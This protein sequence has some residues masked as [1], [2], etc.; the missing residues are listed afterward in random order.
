[1]T[2]A[3]ISLYKQSTFWTNSGFPFCF[4]T[5]P[6][7]RL[8]APYWLDY[9][10]APDDQ[11]TLRIK[12]N[13]VSRD[14]D[15][16]YTEMESLADCY[17]QEQSFFWDQGAQV[18]T[19]H[20]EHE[21]RPTTATM[22]FGAVFGVTDTTVKY[23]DDIEY[24]PLIAKAPVYTK[25][26]DF[27]NYDKLTFA[28]G[29]LELGGDGYL[30]D[31]LLQYPLKGNQVNL[32]YGDEDDD[33]DDLIEMDIFYV[34][35]FSSTLSKLTLELQDLRKS[36]EMEIPISV[37]SPDDYPDLEEDYYNKPVP[38]IYG[39]NEDVPCTPVNGLE[40]VGSTRTYRPGFL[41]TENPTNVMVKIDNAWVVRTP[42]NI[43]LSS[44]TFDVPN[45]IT[46]EG[47]PLECKCDCTGIAVAYASDII[48]DINSRFLNISYV[49]SSYLTSEW[50]T[51]EKLLAPIG[52]VI[53]EK[54]KIFDLIA[55]IQKASSVGF[56][57]EFVYGKRTIRVDNPNRTP[58]KYIHNVEI[59]NIDELPV[60]PDST[61]LYS[62][63]N[64]NYGKNW[65]ADTD[66]LVINDD[67]EDEVSAEHQTK[68]VFDIQ[69]Y[70]NSESEAQGR[71]DIDA[72]NFSQLRPIAP[73]KLMGRDFFDLRQYDIVTVE[74]TPG[75]VDADAG[76]VTGR[77]YYGVVRGQVVKI[78]PD[79]KTGVNEI[80]VRVRPWSDIFNNYHPKLFCIEDSLGG[81]LE[82]ASG[83]CLQAVNE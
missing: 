13:S 38:L 48:K 11:I 34:E 44:G 21:Y 71:A 58:V 17:A 50:A 66:L 68:K 74:L 78:K 35:D 1:L 12:V 73:L 52:M 25:Q 26:S 41:F 28:N 23:F 43:V 29:T 5:R 39:E 70:L 56:V 24:L 31:S 79:F 47:A 82:D 6:A 69:T 37:F 49:S 20:F 81:D 40:T 59:L 45:A 46:D 61:Y 63:I 14:G 42:E 57:Y 3:E 83:E 76:T 55:E 4:E 62:K 7:F 36:R 15:Q 64:V 27:Q 8:Y 32:L 30:I 22:L 72:E 16:Y 10:D 18:L 60:E 53:S 19:V 65:E 2:I 75:F 77:Q 51:E 33:Y 54:R 80:S 67:Y 9:F